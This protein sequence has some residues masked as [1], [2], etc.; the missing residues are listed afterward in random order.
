MQC[1]RNGRL[2]IA[3]CAA[4]M[5]C[6]EQFIAMCIKSVNMRAYSQYYKK[7]IAARKVHGA[8]EE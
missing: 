2:K 3:L 6:L 1:L 8:E 5:F 7:A 4:H